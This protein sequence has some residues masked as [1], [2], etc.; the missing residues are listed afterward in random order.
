V[1]LLRQ[2]LRWRDRHA[3]RGERRG[4]RAVEPRAPRRGARVRGRVAQAQKG[5]ALIA[6][7][8]SGSG[9]VTTRKV[10]FVSAWRL[11]R[12]CASFETPTSWAPQ[13]EEVMRMAQTTDLI[14]RSVRRTRRE[15]RTAPIQDF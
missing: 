8:R 12:R 15:G 2:L 9:R 13:D 14:L 11:H 10:P 1:I 7:R 3:R 5:A 4:A 6:A